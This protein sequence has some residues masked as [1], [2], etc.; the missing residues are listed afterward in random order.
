MTLE[1]GQVSERFLSNNGD[2]YYYV[3][4]VEKNDTQVNYNSLKIAFSEFDQMVEELY[5][6]DKVHVYIDLDKDN[7]DIIDGGDG[8]F[9]PED[10]LGN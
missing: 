9:Q 7:E 8:D 10:G 5:V 3:K 6:Q 1:P 4:L 2:G